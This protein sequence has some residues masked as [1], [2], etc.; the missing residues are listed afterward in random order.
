MINP[1]YNV[2]T[3]LCMKLIYVQN[4]NQIEHRRLTA[5]IVTSRISP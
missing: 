3:Q 2:T 5:S 1:D 4:H